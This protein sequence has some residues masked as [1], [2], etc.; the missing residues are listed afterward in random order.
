MSGYEKILD[1]L[2]RQSAR[3]P[4]SAET[5]AL[6]CD[7]LTAQAHVSI[8]QREYAGIAQIAPTRVERGLPVLPPEAFRA[9]CAALARLCDETCII[10]ARHRADLRESLDAIRVWLAQERASILAFAAEYL[11]DEGLGKAREIGLDIPLLGF[12]LN[13]AL[14][15]FLRTYAQVVSP[16]VDISIWFRTDCPICGGAPDF[17]ALAKETGART[18][19]CARCDF[20]WSFWRGTCPFCEND[21]PD[22]QKY[23]ATDDEVYR[24][25]TCEKCRRYLKTIDLRQT[26]DERILPVERILTIALD[27]AA[28]DT[29][30]SLL[31]GRARRADQ[32]ESHRRDDEQLCTD[33]HVDQKSGGEFHDARRR[34]E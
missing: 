33:Q 6:Y 30:A 26:A 24:L 32:G 16:F 22:Q 14:H 10:T 13:H 27:V 1:E 34:G 31:D 11:R 20:E 2:R 3:H 28:R 29:D 5:L 8:N 21:D 15:P 25:Y 19:L 4:E 9:D 7:L 17:A 23:F 18:L 12:V